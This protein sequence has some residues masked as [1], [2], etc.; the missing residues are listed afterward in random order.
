MNTDD[1]KSEVRRSIRARSDGS[2]CVGW[3][4]LLVFLAVLAGCAVG[5]N[6]KRPAVDTP[7]AF[8]TAASDTNDLAGTNSLADLG[9]WQVMSDPQLQAYI[10]EALTNSWDIKIAA[11]RVLQAEA[12]ARVTRSQFLPTVG[13]GGDW[14]PRAPPRTA[15]RPFP[16]GVNPQQEYGERLRRHGGL[17]SGPLGPD[18]P[19]ERS[20]PRPAARHRGGAADGPPDA[21]GPGGHGLSQPAGTGLRTGDRP[22]HLRRADQLP[23]AHRGARGRRR[24]LDAGRVPGADSGLHRRGRHRRHPSPHRTAGKR[25]EHPARPQ[26]RLD[27]ERGEGFLRQKLDVDGAARAA[28]RPAR[29]PAGHP[30]RGTAT[31][32]RQRR[33]RPGQGRVLPEGD[34]HRLLRLPVRGAVRPVQQ[35]RPRPGSS[36]RRSRCR[37]SPAAPCAAT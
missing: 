23:G 9:W 14:S 4:S 29:A 21:G 3:R 12:A 22:A 26:S 32:R 8:R 25:A 28:V 18:P 17:R 1:R 19:R 5:P 36:A 37:C 27:L 30:R 10:A 11:A 13:A 31:G 15:R 35:R 24:G 6:Y 20:R 16:P 7:A 34:A 33:H 2:R